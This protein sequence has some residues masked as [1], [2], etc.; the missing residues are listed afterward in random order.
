M[1]FNIWKNIKCSK[2]PTSRKHYCR[3]TFYSRSIQS[4]ATST[5]RNL[6]LLGSLIQLT[7]WWYTTLKNHENLR[8]QILLYIVYTKW[9]TNIFMISVIYQMHLM[10]HQY[11]LV[12]LRKKRLDRA[13]QMHIKGCQQLDTT[14]IQG[15]SFQDTSW[16]LLNLDNSWFLNDHQ[17][18]GHL[19]QCWQPGSQ[20]SPSL[21][22]PFSADCT[23]NSRSSASLR[24]S[25][26]HGALP[27]HI[28][29][30]TE[31]LGHDLSKFT[32]EMFF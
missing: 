1:I 21:F 28:N 25:A 6:W 19:P 11:F 29:V 15:L 32:L 30:V 7:L 31:R 24:T 17:I 3:I 22:N 12:K 16:N 9:S 10:Y 27:Y 26:K 13:N 14:C 5:T 4:P 2:P 18:L 8:W 20:V 23:Q